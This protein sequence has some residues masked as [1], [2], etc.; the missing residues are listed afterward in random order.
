MSRAA[1]EHFMRAA[2]RLAESA[3]Q[4]ARPNPTVGCVIVAD[5]K[6]IGRGI[7][8]RVGG[9]HAEARALAEAGAK[10]RDATAYVTLEPCAH[11]GNTPPCVE[12]LQAAGVARVCYGVSDPD[13][14]VAGAGDRALQLAGIQVTSDVLAAETAALHRG[15]LSRIQRRRPWVTLKL[16]A[17]LDGSTAMASG[18]SQWI[19]GPAARQRGHELRAR[20]GAMLVGVGT[21]L[22]DDPQLTAR[23]A[24][25]ECVV[26]PLVAVVDSTLRTPAEAQVASRDST[27][28][29]AVTKNLARSELGQAQVISTPEAGGRCDLPFVLADLARRGVND[30]LVESGPRLAGALSSAGLVDQYHV[31]LAARWLGDQTSRLLTTPDWTHLA[32][33]EALDIQSV[34]QLGG[35][36][37]IVA[38]PK[39]T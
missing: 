34:R 17:S 5:G 29:Y 28:I 39:K 33:G 6:I 14:R 4:R 25:G 9:E 36:L 27:L 37:E 3:W 30:V 15:F 21:I 23:P 31:F 8:E 22:A 32:D 20:S 24:A 35:D 7:S 11:H 19:T 13:P 2:L 26:Q 10:A 12:A 16:A 38:A 1:D 18:E